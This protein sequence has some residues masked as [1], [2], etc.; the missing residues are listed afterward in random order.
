MQK[1]SSELQA[2]RKVVS[3]SFC[4]WE[5]CSVGSGWIK[6]GRA[7]LEMVGGLLKICWRKEEDVGIIGR[8]SEI[9]KNDE[10]E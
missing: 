1:S 10:D 5:D 6:K 9:A 2:P 8:I 3:W 4:S 7:Q